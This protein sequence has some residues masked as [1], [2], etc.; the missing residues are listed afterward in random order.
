MEF[1]T[2]SGWPMPNGIDLVSKQFSHMPAPDR[3][4]TGK[5]DGPQN[6]EGVR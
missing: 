2:T 6:Q 1:T 4:S 3:K 5:A